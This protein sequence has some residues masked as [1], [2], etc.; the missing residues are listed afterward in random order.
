MKTYLIIA[1]YS[2]E[3]ERKRIEYAFDKWK[4][5]LDVTKPT[6]ILAIAEG[7]EDEIKDMLEDLFSRVSKES[8]SIYRMEKTSVDI[9][10]DRRELKV[11]LDERREIVEK[12]IGFMM[13]KQKAV[14]KYESKEPFERAYELYT[15]KGKCEIRIRL[16][17]MDGKIDLSLGI[18]GYGDVVRLLH[19]R[20]G[21][22]LNYFKGV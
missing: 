20:L 4:A 17:E 2:T 3:P 16:R 22:E 21:E 13:A 1:K 14:L 12:F 10:K 15:K 6:G 19:D 9:K 11:Q 7:R 18:S 8:V 5:K